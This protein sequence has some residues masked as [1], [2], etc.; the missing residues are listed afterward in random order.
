VLLAGFSAWAEEVDNP[1]KS[2]KVGD[3][4]EY[5]SHTDANGM[6]MDSKMKQTVTAKTDKEVTVK[7]DTEMAGQT[8]SNEQKIDLTK[9]Y[10]MNDLPAGMPAT[11]KP[12]VEKLKEG[13]EKV[14]VNGKEYAAHWIENKI[15]LHMGEIKMDMQA[16]TWIAKDAPMSGLI[17][18]DTSM[19]MGMKSTLELTGSGSG[20]K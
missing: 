12:K 20:A 15:T 11:M 2:V 16:K 4:V 8:K 1:F 3:W 7:F 17:K 14:T 5:T 6:K 10:D 18:M 13:D 19:S 9:K